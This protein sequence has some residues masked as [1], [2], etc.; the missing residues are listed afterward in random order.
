MITRV[1]I[2]NYRGFK[3]YQLAGLSQVNLFVG[4]NNSG[5]TALLESI[6][7]L[8]SGG[9]PS[10]LAD[11]ASQRGEVVPSGREEPSFLDIS[12]FFYGHDV[13]TGSKF[14]LKSDNGVPAVTVEAVPLGD[15][16]PS[17]ELFE[18]SRML[19]P[20]YALKIEGGRS[21]PKP[22]QTLFLSDE[23]ALIFDPRRPLRRYIG[24][25]RSEGSPIVFITPDSLVPAAL[26]RMWR[27]IINAKK[28][29]EVYQA[30]RILEPGLEDIVFEPG[31]PSYRSY[32]SRSG[33]VVSFKG[34]QRRVPLGSMGDG[35]RRLLA[36]AISL[37]H[38]KGGFLMIDE[39]DTGFHY[40]IMAKMWELVVETA[41]RLDTQVFATTHSSD[42]IKGLGVLCKRKP[43]LQTKVAAHKIERNIDKNVAFTGAD[44]L[45][46][47]EQDIEIR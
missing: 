27:P 3:Q 36:L 39:I 19:R 38:A 40:S 1:D 15:A 24:D 30:M 45:D 28:E 43:G 17:P 12:H 47:V 21:R 42:C 6:H 18:H 35:M 32:N 25:E 20:A 5:K 41:G 10:V 11:A 4:K 29:E 26:G 22:P 33:V 37:I 31:D 2:T 46:A 14:T 13:Q 23:G 34:D 44:V 16:E 8:A 7:F 9:D